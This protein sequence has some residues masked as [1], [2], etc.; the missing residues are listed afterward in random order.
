[1]LSFICPFSEYGINGIFN[2]TINGNDGEEFDPELK[3]Q[4][5]ALHG[6]ATTLDL[7]TPEQAIKIEKCIVCMDTDGI[8]YVSP[9]DCLLWSCYALQENVYLYVK[10]RLMF[11]LSMSDLFDYIN[12][13]IGMLTSS[14]I[15]EKLS[16]LMN[17]V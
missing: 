12:I 13:S 7:V 4:A 3:D 15:G 16:L 8:D 2:T 17:F 10:A 6:Y 5:S 1:M 11:N 14:D 9:W